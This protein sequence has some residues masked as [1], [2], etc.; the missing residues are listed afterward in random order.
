[1]RWCQSMVPNADVRRDIADLFEKAAAQKVEAT[2][3]IGSDL[4]ERG[5]G[6]LVRWT[7][8]ELVVMELTRGQQKGMNLPANGL[9]RQLEPQSPGSEL[10]SLEVLSLTE[11]RLES[12]DVYDGAEPLNGNC[13]FRFDEDQFGIMHPCSLRVRYFKPDIDRTITA[14]WHAEGPLAHPGGRL[15]F[16]FTPLFTP[17]C[18]PFVPGPLALFFQLLLCRDQRTMDECQPISNVAAAMVELS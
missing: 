7:G 17:N 9:L 3:L 16:T 2:A 5:K 10:P 4:T 13:Q 11:I 18:G 15:A 8:H 6:Y 12:P 14:F 1:M